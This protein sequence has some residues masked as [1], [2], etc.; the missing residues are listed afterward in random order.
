MLKQLKHTQRCQYSTV[1]DY[2]CNGLT[3]EEVDSSQENFDSK[4]W[5]S[6]WDIIQPVFQDGNTYAISP[7]ISETDAKKYWIDTPTK[8]YI[9]IFG[10]EIVGSFYVR[11]NFGGGAKDICNCGFI[12]KL[13]CRGR[14]FGQHMTQ[15][16]I[17]I[18]P[19]L[20]FRAMQFNAVVEANIAAV[21]LYKKLGFDLIGKI[22]F[23]FKL[24]N[25]SRSNLLIW[26]KFLLPE[27][28]INLR[29]ENN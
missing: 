1:D 21:H 19:S 9:A 4:T 3:I 15:Y 22:P 2:F 20:G 7:K 17:K 24:S 10:G 12:V 28:D 11:P 23:G 29:I 6:I 25:G 16:A 26:H 14:K 27:K 13:D 8:T 18:S 5:K